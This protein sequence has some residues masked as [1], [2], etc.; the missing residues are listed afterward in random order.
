M[1]VVVEEDRAT[2][3]VLRRNSH[4]SLCFAVLSLY[5]MINAIDLELHNWTSQKDVE[6]TVPE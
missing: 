1:V 5:D 6:K 2:D 4:I 3:L